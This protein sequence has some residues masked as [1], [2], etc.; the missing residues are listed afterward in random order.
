MV[1][2]NKGKGEF[3]DEEET[4]KQIDNPEFMAMRRMQKQFPKP[5]T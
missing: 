3:V 4:L 5:M 1:K 2:R